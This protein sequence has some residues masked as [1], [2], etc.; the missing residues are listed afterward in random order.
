MS[1]ETSQPIAALTGSV[2]Q[3]TSQAAFNRQISEMSSGAKARR[4]IQ[5]PSGASMEE[6]SGADTASIS[7]PGIVAL[8]STQNIGSEAVIRDKDSASQA[9]A[10]TESQITDYPDRATLAQAN[11]TPQQVLALETY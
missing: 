11:Q 10:Y 7:R 5:T 6:K 3:K 8:E 1:I 4:P 2:Q 9:L